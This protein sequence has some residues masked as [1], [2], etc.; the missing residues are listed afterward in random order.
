MLKVKV[1]IFGTIDERSGVN[2]SGKPWE[3]IEQQ[4]QIDGGNDAPSLPFGIR[5]KTTRDG[6]EP[7][8]Y[9]GL[10]SPR[11]GRFRNSIEWNFQDFKRLETPKA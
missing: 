8:F 4:A 11:A 7:G 3:I 1:K 5:L 6:H 9:I 10:L 2:D